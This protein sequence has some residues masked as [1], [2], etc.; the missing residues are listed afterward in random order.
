MATSHTRLKRFKN[1]G[2]GMNLNAPKVHYFS[3]IAKTSAQKFDSLSELPG[4]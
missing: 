2:P 1:V 3:K 4:L